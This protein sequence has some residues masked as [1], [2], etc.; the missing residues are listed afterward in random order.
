MQGVYIPLVGVFLE[1]WP[2][3]LWL[4]RDAWVESNIVGQSERS[5]WKVDQI[6]QTFKLFGSLKIREVKEIIISPK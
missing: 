1:S 6:M 3:P 2:D 4:T 5:E